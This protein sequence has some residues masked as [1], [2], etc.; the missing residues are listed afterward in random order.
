MGDVD[1]A[2]NAAVGQVSGVGLT[3]L[4]D[5]N[6]VN[7]DLNDAPGDE[8]VLRF[9]ILTAPVRLHSISV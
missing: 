6:E 5:L 2:A 7:Y 9:C 3:G 1:S 4:G 8:M